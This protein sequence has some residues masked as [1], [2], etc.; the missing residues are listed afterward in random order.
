MC[1]TMTDAIREILHRYGLGRGSKTHGLDTL[2]ERARTALAALIAN[3]PITSQRAKEVL[4]SG[5]WVAKRYGPAKIIEFTQR[6]GTWGHITILLDDI[7][8][9]NG[10]FTLAQFEAAICLE[11]AMQTDESLRVEYSAVR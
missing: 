6:D 4:P 8:G 9:V 1:D 3:Q 5:E 11:H 10:R 2:L 7:I